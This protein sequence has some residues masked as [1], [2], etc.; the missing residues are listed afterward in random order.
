MADLRTRFE[1][2]FTSL[3]EGIVGDV[4]KLVRQQMA[5]FTAEAGLIGSARK[6]AYW[7]LE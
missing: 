3:L 4:Q 2:S 6:N 7:L 5:M 1:P